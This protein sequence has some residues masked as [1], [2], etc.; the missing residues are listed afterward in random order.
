MIKLCAQAKGLC[1]FGGRV[2]GD[3]LRVCAQMTTG[4]NT[5]EAEVFV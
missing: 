3:Q 5:V 2:V 1:V 4:P